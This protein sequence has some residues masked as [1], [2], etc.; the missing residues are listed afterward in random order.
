MCAGV[1]CLICVRVFL[2]TGIHQVPPGHYLIATPNGNIDI[3]RYFDMNNYPDRNDGPEKDG[4]SDNEMISQVREKLIESIDL[5]MH[6]DV[7]VSVYLSGG[8]DSCSIL[9]IASKVVT[10]RKID[11][12]TISF[13]DDP[14]FDEFHIAQRMSNF[15]NTN[16]HKLEVSAKDIALN[17]ESCLYHTETLMASGNG[18]AKYLLSRLVNSHGKKVVLTGEGS[19]EI[20][21][22][23]PFFKQDFL[24]RYSSEQQ[25]E[26]I[27]KLAGKHL[28][29]LPSPST[30]ETSH[31]IRR[32]LSYFPTFMKLMGE[33]NDFSTFFHESE[34]Q[35]VVCNY[36]P[37]SYFIAQQHGQAVHN[38]YHK[39]DPVHSSMY[40]WCKSFLLNN[41][42]V[43]LG[44]RC[45][46]AHSVEGRVPFL[47]H[48]LVELVNGMP[49][50]IKLRDMQ[51]KYILREAVK[52][53]ITP[54]LYDRQKHPFMAPTAS[55]SKQNN[56][57]IDLIQSTLRS[58]HMKDVSFMDHA[59]VIKLLDSI[60]SN[61]STNS[62]L[63]IP[64]K[65]KMDATLNQLLSIALLQK[66]FNPKTM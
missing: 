60:Y 5:R 38:M 63:D 34:K 15:C 4:R 62:Q 13:V 1:I 31:D 14:K 19:D 44:D 24:L 6:A 54:E 10:Q 52:P 26:E 16:H 45:E 33:Q 25:H 42:L 61:M 37:L 41:L 9:G 23:Y 53:Y 30:T 47:D 59:K 22:G 12:Y 51:E 66:L 29:G 2:C 40:L 18:V 7:P 35:Q 55:I 32:I 27:K 39:W 8:L 64:R 11:A 28:L 3:V 57:M 58:D 46:M 17:F 65:L 21:C 48:E 56:E 43:V 20:F 36:N 50:H 49:L